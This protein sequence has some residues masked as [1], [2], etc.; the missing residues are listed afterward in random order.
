[1]SLIF[2]CRFPYQLYKLVKCGVANE[3]GRKELSP[4]PELWGWVA[5]IAQG[6]STARFVLLAPARGERSGR[7]VVYGALAGVC[8]SF[9]WG[10]QRAGTQPMDFFRSLQE[11][12]QCEMKKTFYSRNW[13]NYYYGLCLVHLMSC[14][15]A[16]L[17]PSCIHTGLNYLLLMLYAHRM[18]AGTA[19]EH[20]HLASLS[21]HA[22]K[23]HNLL[24][25]FTGLFS[26]KYKVQVWTT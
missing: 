17:W 22:L 3:E 18:A 16:S 8:R 24:Y 2:H 19:M 15:C 21:N 6:T 26:I 14:F 5:V 11:G 9:S 12:M 13:L 1:M 10:G 4:A 25:G 7:W 20:S 23:N